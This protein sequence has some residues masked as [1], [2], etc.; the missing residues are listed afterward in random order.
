YDD[1]CGAISLDTVSD[2][3]GAHVQVILGGRPGAKYRIQA[4][5]GGVG[6][7]FT[8]Y[9]V[10]EV[11][12]NRRPSV[13][14]LLAA[15]IPADQYGNF[16]S[17]G[18][19]G[20]QLPVAVECLLLR[21]EK[22]AVGE[23]IYR[24]DKNFAA[25]VELVGPPAGSMDKV[26]PGV[27]QGE[28]TL[29]P[30]PLVNAISVTCSALVDRDLVSQAIT[31]QGT[32]VDFVFPYVAGIVAPPP[33]VLI[34]VNEEGEVNRD[35]EVRYQI[36]P[37]EYQ[38]G[39][40]YLF[41]YRDGDPILII[42]TEAKGIGFATLARGMRLTPG[43]NYE[44]EVV[45][46]PGSGVE[47]K[48]ARIPLRVVAL[49]LDADLNGD[50]LFVEDDPQEDSHP[51]VLVQQNRDD[52]DGDEVLDYDDGFDKDGWSGT[53]DDVILMRN[54]DGSTTPVKDDELV[55]V[56]LTA[57]PEGLG[58]GTVVLELIQG[59]EQVRVW[60]SPDKGKDNVLIE[61]GI[62]AGANPRKVWR[63]GQDIASLAE[64][65]KVLYL[66]GV[67]AA[68]SPAI[69]VSKYISPEGAE[70]EADRLLLTLY[71]LAL[72]P[73]YNRDG[74]IDEADE[75]KVN[76]DK[77]WR[78]WVNDD[79][80]KASDQVSGLGGDDTPGAGADHKDAVV[81]GIRDLVDFF[82]LHLDIAKTL[83]LL[84]PA[85]GYSYAL[86]QLDAAVGIVETTL[87]VEHSNAYLE[88]LDMAAGL[89][90]APVKTADDKGLVLTQAFLEMIAA[91]PAKGVL[92][93]EGRK[94]SLAPLVLEVRDSVGAVILSQSFPLDIM[95]ISK[96]T[97][98]K[99]LRPV[100]GGSPGDPS[101]K[102][103]RPPYTMTK[104]SSKV[105]VWM[106]GYYVNPTEARATYA[107][108]FKRFFHAGLK[109]QF[110]GVS[111]YG[112]PPGAAIGPPHYHQASVNAFATA[113]DFALFV[114]GLDG[115]VSIAAHS[116]GNLVAGCA[117][118]DHNL[119]RF[120]KYFAIDAAVALE[121]YGQVEVNEGMV[122]VEDWLDYWKY[123]GTDLQGKPVSGDKF[124]ASEWYRL[125]AGS[126]DNR[127]YLTW[128]NRLDN[129]PTGKVYN[130]YSSTEEV[131]RAYPDDDLVKY[132]DLLQNYD[133]II[134][135]LSI[136]TWVKQEK[137]KGRNLALN[138][139]GI[140]S[141]FVGWS[142]SGNY[143]KFELF[144]LDHRRHLT[145]EEA[146]NEISKEALRTEPFFAVETSL[147]N[148]SHILDD[149]VASDP[150]DS[151]PSGFVMKKVSATGLAGYYTHNAPALDRVSVKD[152]LLAEA[153][154]ATTL[155]MGANNSGA[156][157][158]EQNID[159]SG[160]KN[161][162]GGCCKTEELRWPRDVP[163]Q[164]QRVWR[165]S[166]YKDVP[167]QHVYGFYSRIKQLSAQ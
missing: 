96:M 57:L 137:F 124:L 128:R 109:G 122:K 71:E 120:N 121:A 22:D 63:L 150:N 47:I 48:S 90:A 77:P 152:W 30:E 129:V 2:Q 55:E 16:I 19:V 51:G 64:L 80:D 45:L 112:D 160:V 32:G 135:Y 4:A 78:F 50:G 49:E 24:I 91:D 81:N 166:D 75:G 72:V 42:P 6:Q 151:V 37:G 89:R 147:L 46:N 10:P 29:P 20:N 123:S 33:V 15:K 117:I 110:Y 133:D 98:H 59:Q 131:L 153:F 132:W 165:H 41:V 11:D 87:A 144:S 43:S 158:Q 125:F 139:G 100:A 13:D 38:A 14:M 114:E 8:R 102:P 97:G 17:A 1:N 126:G 76:A 130:F 31:L 146:V 136:F 39:S 69:L 119:I 83:S 94:E 99:D 148:P 164:N 163:Y 92:L 40:A 88:D 27:Y 21:G 9:S 44:V 143:W 108:V 159:M 138:L 111:W 155:P 58:A 3:H 104:D 93:V 68:S 7:I 154:P 26:S 52:D 54:P 84:P 118:Q 134:G 162:D 116:L 60:S 25:K 53:A 18:K 167:Y 67:K 127:K 28:Y 107:E 142:F 141:P 101:R 79:D 85:A 82:A 66:E 73:D 65:P 115:E 161:S 149:L 103:V 156:I 5:A 70:V 157:K 12:C 105:L 56:H 61:P 36:L 23:R 86:R 34:A 140:S 35:Q 95:P 113:Q 145:P 62:V 106:H 74:K